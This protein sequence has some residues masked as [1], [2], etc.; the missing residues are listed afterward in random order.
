MDDME[1]FYTKDMANEGKRVDLFTPTGEKTEHWIV[2]RSIHSDAYK[3][4]QAEA[5][6]STLG[7]EEDTVSDKNNK[8]LASLIKSWSFKT[9]LT[10]GSAVAFINKAPQIA[11]KIYTLAVNAEFFYKKKP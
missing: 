3:A 5:M 7:G 6:R 4:A 1:L 11:D 9:E 8:V 10:Q 2:I